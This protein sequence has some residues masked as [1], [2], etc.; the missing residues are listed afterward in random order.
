MR[1]SAKKVQYACAALFELA[2]AYKNEQPVQVHMIAARQKLPTNY[3]VQILI[4][5][6]RAGLVTSVR[7]SQGGYRLA[8]PPD[9]IT[10]AQVIGIVDGPICD[11]GSPADAAVPDR[12]LAS[13]WLEKLQ[14]SACKTLEQ[15]LDSV[16]FADIVDRYGG[17]Q[18]TMYYI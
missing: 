12:R 5:L 11:G 15:Q 3:L 8:V 6:R 17:Q 16:S 13:Y 1:L 2:L 9:K 4:A 7:G 14:H 10:V 18:E